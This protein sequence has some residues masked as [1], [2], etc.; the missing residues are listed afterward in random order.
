[1]KAVI[2]AAGKG[3]RLGKLSDEVPKCLLLLNGVPVLEY[4][5]EALTYAGVDEII[6]VAGHL[7]QKVKEF[8]KGRCR[9]IV[10]DQYETTNSIYSLWLAKPYVAGHDF[11]FL[12]GDVI[13]DEK[14]LTDFIQNEEKTTFLIDDTGSYRENECQL[15]VRNGRVVAYSKAISPEESSGESAQL[16][17]FSA[18]DSMVLFKRIEEV[19]QAGGADQ[20]P[21]VAYNVLMESFRVVAV[22]T[23]GRK[24]FEFDTLEDY[25][26]CPIF[27]AQLTR[28][29]DSIQTQFPIKWKQ[30]KVLS[31]LNQFIKGRSFYAKFNRSLRRFLWILHFIPALLRVPK[32]AC[33]LWRPLYSGE[34]T[35]PGF[36]LQVYG[37][38]YLAILLQEARKLSI[39]PFLTW[40]T[41]LGC[42]REGRF[43]KNDHDLDL[44][45][46]EDDFSR[47][48]ALKEAMV[49]KGFQ[50]RIENQHKVSFIHPRC[51]HLY[52]DIDRVYE[53]KGQMV[54]TNSDADD[55]NNYSYYFSPDT[56]SG[57][58]TVRF[59]DGLEALIPQEPEKF[60]ETVYGDWRTP[61]QKSHYLYGPLNLFVEPKTTS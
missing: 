1:M 2:L 17:K 46:L 20:F 19:V 24:W 26:N 54:I 34:L 61:Q 10:N 8:C 53:K 27:L 52:I 47:I 9:V 14:L 60:L 56:F 45:V 12:N 44:A 51:D 22:F 29:A 43:I 35:C 30:N 4:Q 21:F 36:D 13:Y 5:L 15:V 42:V 49:N 16:E 37:S 38:R 11:L 55:T 18:E 23:G 48:V 57:F 33:K 58:K 41:L 59:Q 3:R 28:K 31:R 32:R 6:V 39:R 25:E 50:V 7:D 40:G